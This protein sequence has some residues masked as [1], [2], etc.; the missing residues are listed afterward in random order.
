MVVGMERVHTVLAQNAQATGRVVTTQ[1]WQQLG[2]MAAT[3]RK[4]Q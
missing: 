1:W 2:Q 3:M 4:R